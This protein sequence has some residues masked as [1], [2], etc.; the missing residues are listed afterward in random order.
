MPIG[1]SDGEYYDDHYDYTVRRPVINPDVTPEF[2]TNDQNV[3]TPNQVETNKQIDQ[4][5]QDPSTGTGIPIGLKRVYITRE[6]PENNPSST[7]PTMPLGGSTEPAGAFKS[8]SATQVA[9]GNIDLNKRPIVKNPDGS[10]STVRSISVG[11][12]EGEV[13]IPT[14]AHDGSR[15][16][17]K[18]EAIQQYKDSK[19]HLGIFKT[20]EAATA[21]A[22]Q[23]HK[24]Q[25]AQYVKP[26][27]FLNRLS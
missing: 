27:G 23:L 14:V 5:E 8:E 6:P 19:Q 10:I 9:P 3:V 1:T 16:L 25:E 12:D 7:D 15:I 21:Y 26:K 17:S 11:T 20:P 13:L 22:E 2:M 4:A 18:E 24:D